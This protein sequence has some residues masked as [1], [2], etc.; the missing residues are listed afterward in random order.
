MALHDFLGESDGDLTFR[1]G[2][3]I[4]LVSRMD[5]EW[6]RGSL[7]GKEG[8]FPRGFVEIVKDLDDG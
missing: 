8:I 5:G 4:R 1:E 6:L 2:E 3:L 7:N